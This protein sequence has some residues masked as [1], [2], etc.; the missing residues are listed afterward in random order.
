MARKIRH[1]VTKEW[2]GAPETRRLAT[3]RT[4]KTWLL[5]S[6]F[7]ERQQATSGRIFRVWSQKAKDHSSR[8]SD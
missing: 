1:I 2:Q 7:V 8:G 3:L 4:F 5:A 6:E